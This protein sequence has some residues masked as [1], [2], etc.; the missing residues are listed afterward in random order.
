MQSQR[1]N[2]KAYLENLAKP[3]PS[4][5]GGSTVALSFCLGA[6]LIEK[7]ASYSVQKEKNKRF[8]KAL[9]ALAGLRRRVYP[10]ID[11]DALIFQ[12]LMASRG[13]KRLKF[14]K[15]SENLIAEIACISQK[16]FLLAKA[17]ESG[18]KKSISSDFYIGL[19]L[20]KTAFFGCIAN[21]E[22]NGQLFGRKNKQVAS[23]K[24]VLKKWQN[25]LRQIR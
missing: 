14:I 24:R 4:P 12:K 20:I 19:E 18:I 22:A 11:K 2:F 10:L 6:S 7:A 1:K 3:K 25:S 15:S 9:K 17:L 5:G 23:L 8:R 16:A 21:L 13:L